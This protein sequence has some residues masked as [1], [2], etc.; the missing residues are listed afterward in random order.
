MRVFGAPEGI[1]T[2]DLLIR[3]QALYPAELRAHILLGLSTDS[4]TIIL[5]T[6]AKVKFFSA[7]L[8]RISISIKITETAANILA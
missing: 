1:R 5:D 8:H 4:F 2:P 6:M 7:I 3:S